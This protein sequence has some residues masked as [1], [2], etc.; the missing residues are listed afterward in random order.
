MSE[1][2]DREEER[3]RADVAHV[4]VV[5]GAVPGRI[6]G[7]ARVHV[8]AVGEQ[9]PGQ[10]QTV[11]RAGAHRAG[12]RRP[13]A[14]ARPHQAVE[15]GSARAVGIEVGSPGDQPSRQVV[16]RILDGGGEDAGAEARRQVFV[17][18]L[19]PAPLRHGVHRRF[20]DVRTAGQ[21]RPDRV[22]VTAPRRE[23]Q[24]GHPP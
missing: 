1:A 5:V 17:R 3:R 10:I 24:R 18:V 13:L 16:I 22:Q 2:L 4:G 23:Q 9:Q 6:R 20:V 8:G 19:R 12:E 14:V 15:R 21:Q 11:Q 7:H